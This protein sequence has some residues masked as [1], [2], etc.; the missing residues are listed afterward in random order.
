M[1]PLYLMSHPFLPWMW[2]LFV[3]LDHY[4]SKCNKKKIS[5]S[6]KYVLLSW[7]ILK[8]QAS[9]DIIVTYNVETKEREKKEKKIFVGEIRGEI[10]SLFKI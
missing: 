7:F 3:A 1:S 10:P 2:R 6:T 9:H 4:Y 5:K 8:D